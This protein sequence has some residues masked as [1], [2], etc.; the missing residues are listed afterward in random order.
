MYTNK[1]NVLEL[2]ALLKKHVTTVVLCPGSRNIP[3]VQ[4]MADDPDFT[5]YSITD[6][7]SAGFFA[8]GLALQLGKPVAVCCTS[9][10]ALLNL[11]PAVSE[12]FYQQ[13]P[14]LVIS[15]DR[16]F[17]WVGQMDGQTLPQAR[18]FGQLVK[19]SVDLPEVKDATD[20]WL[21][22]RLVN[23]ALL[24]LEYQVPGPVHINVPI[25][26]PFFSFD[27]QSLPSVREIQRYDSNNFV[28]FVAHLQ[29]DL[30]LIPTTSAAAVAYAAATGAIT[31]PAAKALMSSFPNKRGLT[32]TQLEKVLKHE[33]S[34]AQ[35]S[36]LMALFIACRLALQTFPKIMLIV[37]QTSYGPGL[38]H[39]L[40]MYERKAITDRVFVVDESL[41]NLDTPHT[42]RNIDRTLVLSQVLNDIELEPQLVIT[43]GGHIISKRLKHYLRQHW[44]QMHWHVAPDGAI[45][46]LYHNLTHVLACR[47]Q[48][49]L[50]ALSMAIN[51]LQSKVAPNINPTFGAGPTLS[52]DQILSQDSASNPGFD[53][54]S[55]LPQ[56]AN[57]NA[58]QGSA[59]ASIASSAPGLTPSLGANSNPA[60]GSASSPALGSA[61]SPALGVSAVPDAGSKASIT[62]GAAAQAQA[63]AQVQAQ[64]QAQ[65]RAQAHA[66]ILAQASNR[67][68]HPNRVHPL[69][70]HSDA[71]KVSHHHFARPHFKTQSY[72]HKWMFY[73]Q[74]VFTPNF[75]YSQMQA[76][77]QTIEQL[78]PG[79]TLHLANSSTVRYAQMFDMPKNVRVMSNR[80]VNGIEGSMSTALG[81]AAAD[82]EHLNF[83]LIGDLSFFYDLN[84]T[85]NGHVASNVRIMLLNNY[86]GE[87]FH[88]LPNLK[89]SPAAQK[90][91]TAS[92]NTNAQGWVESLGF[93]YLSAHEQNELNEAIET[94]VDP[95]P[96][97]QPILLEVFTSQEEDTK[98]LKDYMRRLQQLS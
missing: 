5:C 31:N 35:Q 81:Y 56:D 26:E 84:A 52:T 93:T 19:S 74:Q 24:A 54:D 40:T 53:T 27:V 10:S 38:M 13:I 7:R 15:A 44:P 3:L 75:A 42:C 98:I 63:Q 86:G 50:K 94:L 71:T 59:F 57:T 88:A 90:F 25:S 36:P 83:I 34:T 6:E 2:L 23:E 30:R 39:G 33:I 91:I 58:P 32:L 69:L 92:H 55:S 11:H 95:N 21:C 85:W 18:V 64:A 80:G 47:P 46:D 29:Q 87:I 14:L 78:P 76:I 16:P 48:D 60:L 68:A 28:D 65:A 20:A 49:F 17:A 70:G 37:G 12:A 67:F 66:K 22:N 77:G 9:G 8:I 4:S 61:S 82:P 96:S 41:S 1:V 62:P 97:A 51:D 45:V 73:S 43:L 79:S 72:P 89:L